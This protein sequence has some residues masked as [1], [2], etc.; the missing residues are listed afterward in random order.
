MNNQTN[1]PKLKKKI[2]F[3][4]LKKGSRSCLNSDPTITTLTTVTVT[5]YTV[6]S[7]N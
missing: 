6:M 2:V 4:F 7:G 3:V 5:D 1:I